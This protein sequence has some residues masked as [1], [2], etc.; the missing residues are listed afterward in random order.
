MSY[1]IIDHMVSSKELGKDVLYNFAIA[2]GGTLAA[3]AS[4]IDSIAG[5]DQFGDVADPVLASATQPS[6]AVKVLD[7]RHNA[8]YVWSLD[9]LQQQLQRMRNLTTFIDRQ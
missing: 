8:I 7:M 1:Q 3:P 4:A 5:L 6:V 2:A 9:R